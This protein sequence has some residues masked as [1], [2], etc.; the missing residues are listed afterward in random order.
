MT[1]PARPRPIVL[2]VIDGFGIGADPAADAIAAAR[3]PRWRGLLQRWPHARLEA[4]GEAVGLPAGQMGNSEVGHLNIGAGRPVQQDLPRIDAAIADGSFDTRPALLAACDRAVE[5][6]GTLHVVSLIGPGGVHANDRHLVALARLAKAR[7][8]PRVRVHALL[9]G[10]D[11][12]PSS[13]LGFVE[14]L[15]G[16]LHAAHPDARIATVGGR[17]FAMD[18]DNRWDRTEKGYDA[19]VHGEGRH[20]GSA[21]A[22]VQEAYERGETDE[23]V[24]P[25]VIDGVDGVVRDGDPIVHANFRADRAR[26]LA[27][28]LA[29]DRF[30]GFD[31]TSPAGRPAP[32]DLLV[33]TMTEYEEGLP[34]EVAFP[35]EV[36]PCLAGAIAEAG[37]RQLHV[38]ETE[39]YAHVTYF[40]NGGREAP[41]EGE[42]RVLV[43][44]PKVATYDLQPEM[45]AAGV[46]DAL[47]AG[48]ASG[49]YD[50]LVANFANPDMV[51]HTGVWD[52]TVRACETVDGCLGRVVE[53]LAPLGES[54][55]L[56]IVTADHGN[57]DQ[58]RD[59]DGN[60]VTAH[61]LNPV[62]V[63]F[64]GAA[65]EGVGLRDGVLADV[66][67]TILQLAGL[68]RWAGMTGRSLLAY[69][70]AVTEEEPAP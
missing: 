16:R 60:P 1:R 6:K 22:A 58:L 59:A 42:D 64:A 14:D 61:S 52:A 51:G 55:A 67:P 44:S 69:H 49:D 30:E 21:S 23:F 68:P 38:A 9:D 18:R 40:L 26:Q 8:V 7:G 4:S 70:P 33:V 12:P 24:L 10:R 17:Y 29:D 37:W 54:G 3:M 35:P 28:A 45:S 27:H 66:A 63:V 36:V 19:I 62:P 34:V 20:A 15:E 25:T 57:A 32:R 65:A 48:I 41:F 47:V 56:L 31:R 53:A 2:I 11:T 39:K 43:P 46:T 50:F 5:R 13:A